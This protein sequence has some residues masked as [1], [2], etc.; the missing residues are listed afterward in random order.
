MGRNDVNKKAGERV[1]LHCHTKLSEQY[2]VADSMDLIARAYYS[3]HPAIA[4]TDYASVRAFPEV[5]KNLEYLLKREEGDFKVIYGLEAALLDTDHEVPRATGATVLVQNQRGLINMFRFISEAHLNYSEDGFHTPK[6]ILDTCRE[7]LLVGS[8]TCFDELYQAVL[9]DKPEDEIEKIAAWYD[10]LELQP[11]EIVVAE[12]ANNRSEI[13]PLEKIQETSIQI[14]EL[15][16]KLGKPVVATGN[17]HFLDPDDA[18][19]RDILMESESP[20]ELEQPPLYFRSTGNMLQAF[21]YLGEETAYEIVVLNTQ[22][23]ADMCE[24]VNPISSER[25]LPELPNADEELSEICNMRAK[26]LY[27]DPMPEWIEERLTDELNGIIR[28]HYA[29]SILLPAKLVRKSEEDGYLV[30]A[31]GSVAGSF[32]AYLCGI[33]EVNPLKA[34]YRC[35]ECH[36]VETAEDGDGIG[37]D[38]HDKDCPHCHTKLVKDG[39]NIPYEPFFGAHFDKEP[40]IDLNFAGEEQFSIQEYVKEIPGIGETYLA[41]TI[42]TVSDFAA[43][44]MVEAYFDERGIEGKYFDKEKI[45][46]TIIG[47]F[48][49]TGIHP[50]GVIAVPEGVDI[51]EITPIQYAEDDVNSEML[52]THFEYHSIDQALLKLDI[53]GHDDPSMLHML[54][55]LTGVDP[56]SIDIADEK[57]LSLFRLKKS[58]EQSSDEEATSVETLGIP[59]FGTPFVQGMLESL[60]PRTVSDLIKVS[61]LSHGTNVWTENGELLVQEGHTISELISSRDDIFDELLVRGMGRKR[62]YDIME[63]V[64][65]GKGLSEDMEAE[66]RDVGIPDWYID[67][68][69]KIRYLFPRAHAASYVLNAL[70]IAF[71]KV[72][73]PLEFYAAYFSIRTTCFIT[74]EHYLDLCSGKEALSRT[75][76]RNLEWLSGEDDQSEFADYL[77][78]ELSELLL[79][80]EFYDRGFSF[81]EYDQDVADSERFTIVDGKLMIPTRIVNLH[82]EIYDVNG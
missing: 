55:E 9:D 69:N 35:P 39:F 16:R 8:G 76:D 18:L 6:S 49:K 57:V 41:G 64:R 43:E 21:S 74:C 3:G 77:H 17:V 52:A 68:C 81:A 54:H 45:K 11:M 78:G 65:K 71:Y 50:G 7:G 32:V 73:Y 1:E 58:I 61:L 75:I 67:S 27:G 4:I 48:R 36:Y 25:K 26:E 80:Q 47:S 12:F 22:K 82:E 53:L 13:I 28:N 24:K 38:L 20:G 40:D 60:E 62:A 42:G 46:E 63:N 70:R 2:S 44:E 15:G 19:P 5:Q 79:I 34:H 23:I 33:T 10:F 66:M 29:T 31:R 37:V 51:N 72:N 14:L 56:K 30:G 59:E